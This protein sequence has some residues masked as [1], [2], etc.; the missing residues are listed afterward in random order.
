MRS[1]SFSRRTRLFGSRMSPKT[2]AWVGQAASQAVAT[3]PSGIIASPSPQMPRILL[4]W[5][6]SLTRWMQ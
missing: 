1:V 3:I 2:I 5:R 4:S 6:A